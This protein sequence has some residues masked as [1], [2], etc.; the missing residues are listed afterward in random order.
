MLHGSPGPRGFN[1]FISSLWSD[2]GLGACLT[3]QNMDIVL[4]QTIFWPLWLCFLGCCL[5]ESLLHPKASYFCR[6]SDVLL[7][8]LDSSVLFISRCHL[9]LQDFLAHRLKTAPK[10]YAPTTML[11]CWD[12]V[13]GNECFSFFPPHN[14]SH[15]P[16]FKELNFCLIWPQDWQ[17]KAFSS[18]SELPV[19]PEYGCFE[20]VGYSS[21]HWRVY[22][23]MLVPVWLR[24]FSN[25]DLWMP[26]RLPHYHSWQYRDHFCLSTTM[27]RPVAT[28]IWKHRNIYL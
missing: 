27:L 18:T 14:K 3:I 28:D 25:G 10:N 12:G 23:E 6:L 21:V 22:L 26:V 20:E 4:C 9:L 17:P 24:L 7:Q 11:D 19:L 8:N 5:D 1:T 15:I 13:L 2:S 16:V